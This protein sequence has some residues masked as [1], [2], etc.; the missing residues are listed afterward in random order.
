M[1]DLHQLQLLH[2]Y[3]DSNIADVVSFAKQ[4]HLRYNC[5]RCE[6][7]NYVYN[8]V[9]YHIN[10]CYVIMAIQEDIYQKLII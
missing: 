10:F 2:A 4:K 1:L 3:K 8:Y 6:H 7:S 5:K 9:H